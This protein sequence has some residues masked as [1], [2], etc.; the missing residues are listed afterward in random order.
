MSVLEVNLPEVE[1]QKVVP[2]LHDLVEVSLL[3]P[4]EMTIQV[5]APN[6][7]QNLLKKEMGEP[8][9]HSEK[10]LPTPFNRAPEAVHHALARNLFK[11][12]MKDQVTKGHS[13]KDNQLLL[14]HVRTDHRASPKNHLRN[15]KTVVK[16]N[17]SEKENPVHLIHVQK[18]PLASPRSH[19]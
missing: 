19:L 15:G 4:E 18:S 14:I 10:E 8:E 6:D 3:S 2:D 13:K 5:N 12:E 11:K 16:I 1:I 9:V 17:H 7:F